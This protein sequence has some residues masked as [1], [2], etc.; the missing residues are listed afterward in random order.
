M[1]HVKSFYHV[2]IRTYRNCMSI[3]ENHEKELYAYIFGICQ[4]KRVKLYR[5]GGMPDHLHLLVSLPSYMAISIFVQEIKA[6]S[7]R[8]LKHN[9]AF[10]L[11][12]KWSKEYAA[13]SYAEKDKNMITNYIKRQKIHHKGKDFIDEYKSL[14][15]ENCVEFEEN[16]IMR[17]LLSS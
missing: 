16:N 17:D 11:F 14:L 10:P 15:R 7:S 8:W 9:P 6:S 13:F 2:V 1:S 4:Q 12:C 5:I 3:N